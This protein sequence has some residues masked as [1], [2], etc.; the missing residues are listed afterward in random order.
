[1]KAS[2]SFKAAGL[3]AA[4]SSMRSVGLSSERARCDGLRSQNA[5]ARKRAAA[6]RTR[7]SHRA[8]V[9][10]IRDAI[11]ASERVSPSEFWKE[12]VWDE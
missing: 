7:L 1:M 3:R 9:P 6:S 10:P 12:K 2:T 4:M 11:A 8:S 5:M